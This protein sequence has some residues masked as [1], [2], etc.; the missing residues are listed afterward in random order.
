MGMNDYQF[1]N[2]LC[3]LCEE[4][5]LTQ[6]D[7]AKELGVTPAAVSKWENGS[8]KPR[9]EIL[10]RLA[11]LLEVR[12]EELMAGHR[13][14]E[15]TIYTE[16]EKE[17][18]RRYE[19]LRKI[20]AHNT[21]GVKFRRI[22]AWL[23]DW[24]LI[25]AVVIVISAVYMMVWFEDVKQTSAA[26]AVL[27]VMLIILLYP[28]C[29]ILR[30]VIGGGRSVGKR[31]TRLM[32]LDKRTAKPAKMGKCILRNLLLPIAQ[33]DA[34]VLLAS[35]AT[36]GDR[37]AQTVVVPTKLPERDDCDEPIADVDETKSDTPPETSKG[38]RIALIIVSA[39]V[40]TFGLMLSFVMYVRS[41]IKAKE[42]YRVAYQYF[43]ESETFAQLRA[44]E[45][46]IRMWE[47]TSYISNA[48]EGCA[49]GK[50]AKVS[51]SVDFETYEIVCH[52]VNGVWEVCADCT[53]VE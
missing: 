43:V 21:V 46:E 30:D 26:L 38:K 51:F 8:S 9:V 28:V 40:V 6:A 16:A 50:T 49:R 19:Y 4:K 45:S 32:I 1:G 12:P 31:I 22:F 34:I 17:I 27:A 7:V 48:E 41:A 11:Q 52:E 42:E 23:I 35:G 25:G 2:F 37:L 20:D 18:N 47:Y 53:A 5:R 24:N 33:A 10:F 39:A 15:D 14:A 13:I 44:E 29:F 3:T 36:V